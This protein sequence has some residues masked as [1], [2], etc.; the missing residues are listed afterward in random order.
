MSSLEP[1]H[2]SQ[3]KQPSSNITQASEPAG[4]LL[5]GLG[6]CLL[7]GPHQTT[8]LCAALPVPLPCLEYRSSMTSTL[9]VDLRFFLSEA[10]EREQAVES[11]FDDTAEAEEGARE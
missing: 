5:S 7:V 3:P 6:D 4:F 8:L 11:S 1:Q 2:S 9:S 10:E